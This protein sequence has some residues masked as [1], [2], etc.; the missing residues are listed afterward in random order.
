M[1]NSSVIQRLWYGVD[2]LNFYVR[3]DFKNGIVPGRDLPQ[4]LNL[5]WF[6]P[7]RTMHNSPISIADVPDIAPL[8]YHYHHHL[9]I[10]LLTQ[11]IQF[12]E[13]GEDYQAIVELPFTIIEID[14]I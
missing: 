7:D 12:Q 11:S 13:A 5:L 8:N 6:Y 10:N 2:H 9:E 3:V 1:H 4:E 14:E